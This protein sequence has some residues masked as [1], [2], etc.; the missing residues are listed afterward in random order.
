MEQ[1]ITRTNEIRKK[2][3]GINKKRM[4]EKIMTER[5]IRRLNK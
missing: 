1:K 2:K 5:L 4:K 3:F